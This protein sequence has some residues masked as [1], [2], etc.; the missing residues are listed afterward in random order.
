M[1]AFRVYHHYQEH[2]RHVR[3][4]G[5]CRMKTVG[6]IGR[7]GSKWQ[8]YTV[9]QSDAMPVKQMSNLVLVKLEICITITMSRIQCRFYTLTLLKF[10]NRVY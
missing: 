5:G 3:Q 1:E 10:Q 8:H 6:R 7:R 4:I 2:F 9:I